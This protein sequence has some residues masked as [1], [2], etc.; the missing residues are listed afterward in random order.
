MKTPYLLIAMLVGCAEPGIREINLYGD[1]ATVGVY[2]G[3]CY[4]KCPVYFVEAQKNGNV[5]MKP[6]MPDMGDATGIEVKR[7]IEEATFTKIVEA[8]RTADFA[9]LPDYTNM[10][11]TDHSTVILEVTE[12]ERK[13]KLTHYLG[14]VTAPQSLR[15]LET[16][17]DSLL[18]SKAL[19]EEMKRRLPN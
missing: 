13:K 6:A 9:A 12:G 2:R 1:V 14:D 16:E 19:Y 3:P 11:V 15:D 10:D 5:V 17:I 7:T 8:L 18:G 4:G